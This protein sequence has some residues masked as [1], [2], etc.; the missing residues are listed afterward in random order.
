MGWVWVDTCCIDKTSSA[1]LSEAINSMFSW[2]KWATVCYAYLSDVSAD[3]SRLTDI[4][5]DRELT[6]DEMDEVMGSDFARC[7][8]YNRGWTLQELIAPSEIMFYSRDWKYIGSKR[9][10]SGIISQVTGINGEVL[11]NR[12][13]LDHISVAQRLSWASRR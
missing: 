5:S 7:R 4:R 13:A 11:E 1:E 12:V 8:W 6:D 10:L 9:S 2:Y 3:S